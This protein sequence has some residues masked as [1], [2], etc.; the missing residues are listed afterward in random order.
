[1]LSVDDAA[2]GGNQV[3]VGRHERVYAVNIEIAF[4]VRK[5]HYDRQADLVVVVPLA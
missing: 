3:T 1:V 2:A 5:T 4:Y